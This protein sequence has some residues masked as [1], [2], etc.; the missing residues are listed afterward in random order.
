ME[1]VIKNN[2]FVC[3]IYDTDSFIEMPLKNTRKL[4]KLM[5]AEAWRNELSIEYLRQW[6]VNT[7]TRL[8]ADVSQREFDLVQ[9]AHNAEEARRTKEAYGSVAT[10]EVNEAARLARKAAVH[11]ER[12][13][14]RAKRE[15]EKSEKLSRIFAELSP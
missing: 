8:G 3:R 13:L 4:W 1:I 9:A 12:E 11:A 10:K 14:K 6:L 7:H 5:F 2:R 15:L